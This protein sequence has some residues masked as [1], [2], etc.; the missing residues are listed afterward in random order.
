MVQCLTSM[1]PSPGLVVIAVESWGYNKALSRCDAVSYLNGKD[2]VSPPKFLNQNSVTG[3]DS[4]LG[5]IDGSEEYMMATATAFYMAL[6]SQ[7]KSISIN[8]ARYDLLSNHFHK[9]RATWL[10]ISREPISKCCFGRQRTNQIHLWIKHAAKNAIVQQM[11]HRL[12]ATVYVK[13]VVFVSIP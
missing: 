5:E 1:V 8:A 7:K 3:L 4:V 6:Y 10:Y 9:Q 11:L 12:P 13:P 2:K